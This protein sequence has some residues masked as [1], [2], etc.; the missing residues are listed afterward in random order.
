M[1]GACWFSVEIAH[2]MDLIYF[3]GPGIAKKCLLT[4]SSVTFTY[5]LVDKLGE[6][7]CLA[8]S[9]PWVPN[10]VLGDGAQES[11]CAG[12]KGE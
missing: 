5:D 8:L 12:E 9:P 10:A 3:A 7:N 11:V 2:G 6:D 1:L 4:D